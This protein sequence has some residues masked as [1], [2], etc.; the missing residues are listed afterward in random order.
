MYRFV[1]LLATATLLLAACGDSDSSEP[2]ADDSPQGSDAVLVIAD[3]NFGDPITIDAGTEVQITN[4]D[5]AAHTWTSDDEGL[6]DSGTLNP[7]GTFSFTFDEPGEYLFHC[8]FH[9]SMT[10]SITVE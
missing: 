3:F 1:V 10:G 5:S 7:D 9:I 4:A 2:A 8:N 6:F